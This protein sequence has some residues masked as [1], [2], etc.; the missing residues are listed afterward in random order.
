MRSSAGSAPVEFMVFHASARVPAGAVS[1]A[2]MRHR[3][4]GKPIGFATGK[5]CTTSG[6]TTLPCHDEQIR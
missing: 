6:D 1:L 3:V 2:S 5:S 4:A